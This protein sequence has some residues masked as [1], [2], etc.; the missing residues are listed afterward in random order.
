MLI[1]LASV[2]RALAESGLPPRF[3]ELELTETVL[4]DDAEQVVRS[5]W[6]VPIPF[7]LRLPRGTVL[8]GRK[9]VITARFVLARQPLFTPRGRYREAWV[10]FF[11]VSGFAF[12]V[13][14]TAFRT[15]TRATPRAVP[16]TPLTDLM[17]CTATA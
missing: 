3:L 4:V 6:Q 10:G 12:T 17:P 7:A 13:S 8:E 2:R 16:K 11:V 9:M 15:G 14:A 1:L 5:G